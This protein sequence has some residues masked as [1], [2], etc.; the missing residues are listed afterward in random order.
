[1]KPTA[2]ARCPTPG[3]P[4]DR[5]RTLVQRQPLRAEPENPNASSLSV[6]LTNSRTPP[7]R[8]AHCET[9]IRYEQMAASPAGGIFW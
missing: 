3:S 7:A 5:V 8:S 1:M 4:F 2:L 9:Q 6:K